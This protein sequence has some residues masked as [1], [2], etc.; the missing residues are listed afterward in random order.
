MRIVSW[1]I[2]W[3]CGKDGRIR[4]HAIIDVLRKL[5]PEVICLQEVAVNHPELEGNASA[6]QNRQLSGAFGGYHSVYAPTSEIYRHNLPRLFGNLLLSKFRMT[7]VLRHDLPW[8]ADPASPAGMPRGVIEAVIDAPSGKLRVLTTHLE[9]YSLV[10][11]AAQVRHL[12]EL[13]AQAC[14]RARFYQPD[15]SLDAPFQLGERPASAI[16]CGDFNFTPNSPE[17]AAMLA[18]QDDGGT[19]L[20]DTWPLLHPDLAR[21]PTAGLHGFRWPDKPDCY[22]YFFVTKDLLP[23]VT[24]MDV[25][26]ETSASDHQPIYL[27]IT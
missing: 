24:D 23:R 1:N 12:R 10:Q 14:E 18:P 7:Q 27:D 9:H 17:Y 21:A 5:N 13:H 25:H 16:Y 2:R 20:A 22:D 8:P 3:G 6:N 19:P 4:I 15:H 26:S 11:R